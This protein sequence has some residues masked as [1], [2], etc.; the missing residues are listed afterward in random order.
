M[1][2]KLFRSTGYST[3]LM[4]GEARLAPMPAWAV[5]A[6]SGWIALACNVSLWRALVDMDTPALL[7]SL[8]QALAIGGTVGAFL[9]VVCWRRTLKPLASTLLVLS[10]TSASST[11][12]HQLPSDLSGS[13]TERIFPGWA[14]LL[15]W[16][17]SVMLALLGLVPVLMLWTTHLRR[18]T[19]P[20]QLQSNL[21]GLVLGA[22][23]AAAGGL[24]LQ[25]AKP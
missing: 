24:L 16:R 5:A 15:D 8:A 25:A 4:P 19:G 6:A 18:L 21:K 9:S 11:W 20:V 17:V 23:L 2:L 1:T 3:M 7:A 12:L 10:A 22:A 14:A 13:F